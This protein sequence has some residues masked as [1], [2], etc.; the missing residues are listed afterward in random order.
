MN[1]ILFSA[2]IAALF[3]NVANAQ[4]MKVGEFLKGQKTT[5]T[6]LKKA[7][8]WQY[9]PDGQDFVC[10]NGENRYTR[11]LYGSHDE[12]RIETSDRPVF[13]AY[14]K[15][16]SRNISFRITVDGKTVS[17]EKTD[18][19]EARYTARQT[20]VH[21]ARQIVGRRNGEDFRSCVPRQARRD[22]EV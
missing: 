3:C 2:V 19:C 11:A 1:K 8:K 18:Y 5:R 15:N 17:L 7:R 10:V 20:F 21:A 6:D 22:M 13:V 4:T 9:R 14:K 12:D 16:D